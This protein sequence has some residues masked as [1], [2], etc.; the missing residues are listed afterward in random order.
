L[1]KILVDEGEQAHKTLFF[2]AM[3]EFVHLR[4]LDE[5]MF[6]EGVT[7]ILKFIVSHG[8]SQFTSDE[9]IQFIES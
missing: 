2:L 3:R 8:Q 7:C 4:Q 1:L 6:N 5:D 9:E